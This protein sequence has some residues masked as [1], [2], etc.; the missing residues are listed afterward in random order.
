M[1]DPTEQNIEK[2]LKMLSC[3]KYSTAHISKKFNHIKFSNDL[4][5]EYKLLQVDTQVLS[6]VESGDKWVISLRDLCSVTLVCSLQNKACHPRWC[7]RC[8]C[9]LHTKYELPGKRGGS[10]EH[11]AAFARFWHFN[12]KWW[13]GGTGKF[14]NYWKHT[15]TYR[16]WNVLL[17]FHLVIETRCWICAVLFGTSTKPLVTWASWKIAFE[18][19][20]IVALR[21][22]A[23][24]RLVGK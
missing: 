20:H 18:K 5:N 21:K 1:D 23:V 24:W 14:T 9:D 17:C 12:R 3:A 16:L 22:K 4:S 7:Q 8:S 2:L 10:F 13:F 15:S 6:F 19:L 11:D